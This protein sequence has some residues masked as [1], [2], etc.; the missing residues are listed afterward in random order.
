MGMA[1]PGS[2]GLE[3]GFD[4][5]GGE[6]FLLR[7]GLGEAGLEAVAE[8]HQFV[9]FGDDAVLFAISTYRGWSRTVLRSNPSGRIFGI[10]EQPPRISDEPHGGGELFSDGLTL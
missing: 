5:G 10:M 7:A 1:A 6:A 9:D 4:E 2:G 8:G 3:G